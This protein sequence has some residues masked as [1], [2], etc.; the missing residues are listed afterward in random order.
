LFH[1]GK[2]TLAGGTPFDVTVIVIVAGGTHNPL[3]GVYEN[4]IERGI[5]CMT[6]PGPV[7][8]PADKVTAHDEFDEMKIGFCAD[9]PAGITFPFVS[10]AVRLSA[11]IPGVVGFG[12]TGSVKLNF[13]TVGNG[14]GVGAGVG[15]GQVTATGTTMVEPPGVWLITK[16]QLPVLLACGGDEAA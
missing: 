12:A 16:E 15:A 7:C 4:E 13:A 9:V 5:G 8:M 2:L 1:D 6:N 3:G 14:V 10:V 11:Y